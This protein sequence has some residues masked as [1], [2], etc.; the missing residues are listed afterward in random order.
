MW[1][2]SKMDLGFQVP[3]FQGFYWFSVVAQVEQPLE[4]QIQDY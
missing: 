2:S 1:V 4:S 3:N